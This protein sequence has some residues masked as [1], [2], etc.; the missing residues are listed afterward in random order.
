MSLIGTLHKGLDAYGRLYLLR[1]PPVVVLAPGRVGSIALNASLRTAGVFSFK[2]EFIEQDTR[3]T[4]QF[5]IKHI[6]NK[7]KPAK[8]ITLVR[9]PISMML[10]YY[11]SK[12]N[13]G[14]LPEA[15]QALEAGDLKKLKERFILDVLLTD[16]LKSHL[17]W[18]TT[19][20]QK[21]TGI[22]VYTHP[23]NTKKMWSTIKHDTYPTL[24]LRTELD[25]ETKSERIKDF[26]ELEDFFL[27]R[28]NT[29]ETKSYRDIY[30]EFKRTL[31]LPQELLEQIYT[32]PYCKQFL[33]EKEQAA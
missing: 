3:G 28:L 14:W 10:T 9:D 24:I 5:A 25:D 13:A 23:F 32:H 2:L 12:A 18:F 29:A 27:T 33:M 6:F 15:K 16:R 22:D 8:L 4:A 1:T 26:L 19:D 30:Q 20:F 17:D 31:T 21:L 7:H 11:M